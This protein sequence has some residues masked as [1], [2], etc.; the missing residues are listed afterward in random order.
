[1]RIMKNISLVIISSILS[2]TSYCSVAKEPT[3]AVIAHVTASTADTLSITHAAGVTQIHKNPQRVI[4]FD[5]GTYDSLEKLGLTSHVVG[6]PKSIPS[7][8]KGKVSSSMTEVGGMKDPDL[9]AIA[10]LQPDLIIITGRQGNSYDA[11]SAIAPTI[12][13]ATDQ[14]TYFSS[15][16]TNA[17]LLGQ[18]FDKKDDVAR[19]IEALSHQIASI[20]SDKAPENL[21]ALTLIHNNGNFG[22]THQ[23]IVFDVLGMKQAKVTLPKSDNKKRI[24]LTTHDIAQANP[25]II[26]IVDRSAAI[27]AT[28]LDK[29]KFEDDNLR[30][31]PAFKNG[32]IVY[33]TPDLWY[34]SGAGLESTAAQLTEVANAL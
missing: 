6:L 22:V 34:L 25:D 14:N 27:G 10:L 30:S 33:L 4:L 21:T 19:Y 24:P 9:N 26:F 16:K 11:L 23:P 7:Y 5:F 29:T 17:E 28:P 13:L 32:K 2:F 18:I 12:S 15:V 3:K 1:M 31:T 20:K 8:I